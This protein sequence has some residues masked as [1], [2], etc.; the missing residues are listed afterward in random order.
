M[1]LLLLGKIYY[2]DRKNRSIPLAHFK[3]VIFHMQGAPHGIWKVMIESE[4]F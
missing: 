4:K 2:E 1:K 3:H